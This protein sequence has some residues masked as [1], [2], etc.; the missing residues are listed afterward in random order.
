MNIV[1]CG[2]G[3]C[4]VLISIAAAAAAAAASLAWIACVIVWGTMFLGNE[5]IP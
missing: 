1:I 3:D 5:S 2:C 4:D